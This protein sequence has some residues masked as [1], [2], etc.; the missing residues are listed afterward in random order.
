MAMARKNSDQ[1]IKANGDRFGEIAVSLDMTGETEVKQ[2]LEAQLAPG[3]DQGQ[4]QNETK[5]R[6]GEI[7]V[8]IRAIKLRDVQ[9]VLLEQQR[10]RKKTGTTKDTL[11][12]RKRFGSFELLDKLGEGG[13][14][15][16]YRA[17]DAQMGRTVALKVLSKKVLGD[18]K[19]FDRFKRE[20]KATASLNHPNIVTAYG[21]GEVDGMPYI[22][23][24]YV[25]GENLRSRLKKMGALKEKEA[26]TLIKGAAAGLEHAHK[27]G[28]IHRDVKPDNI[29]VG[30]DGTVKIADLGLAKSVNDDQRLTK[31]GT[32]IGTPHYISPE[33]ARGDKKIDH[34]SDIY[35][36][37]A[38]L[39][40]MLTGQR[41]FHGRNNAEIMLKHLQ[42]ELENP[43]DIVPEISDGA[44]RIVSRM[45]GKLASDRYPN[46]RALIADIDKVLSAADPNLDIDLGED[47]GATS[48]KPPRRRRKRRAKKPRASGGSG[49]LIFLVVGSSAVYLGAHYVYPLLHWG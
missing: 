11:I 36:L 19:F 33:Q 49:C 20:I 26:L 42:E 15:A 25:E 44:E 23:M 2:A 7:L 9:K 41:P 43:Q 8:E 27:N 48:I 21:A 6:L 10:R 35:S 39:Y 30:K 4:G 29:L 14:G 1:T 37:G 22:A 31:T 12:Q 13:M 16:V 17:R 40:V 38:T 32:A 5:K 47:I 18:Q 46:C 28:V 24:E 34:R 3:P 45:M